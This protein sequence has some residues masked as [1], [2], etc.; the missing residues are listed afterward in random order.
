MKLISIS[1]E[2][3]DKLYI[4][5]RLNAYQIAEKLNCGSTTVYRHLEKYRIKRR[6]ISECHIKYK[7]NRFSGNKLE[8]AYLIGFRLGDLHVRKAINSPGCKT[9]RV[10]AHT[11]KP[12]QIELVKNLF[13]KYSHVHSKFISNKTIRALCFLDNSFSFILPKVDK[14]ENWIES[15]K[16]LFLAFLAGYVDAEGHIS[17]HKN[18]GAGRLI[19][20]TQDKGIIISIQQNLNKFKIKCNKAFVSVPAGYRSPSYPERPNN[21]DKWHVAVYMPDLEKLLKFLIPF[22]KHKKRKS[23]A[24]KVL[25]FV[26]DEKYEKR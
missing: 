10:E 25:K 20:E 23:D 5:E 21:K 18:N 6:D 4:K 2:I 12:D 17:I 7:K 13:S 3:L 9:I 14:I 24:I 8:M 16:N 11:T 22:L 26:M 19:I 1:K 15:D